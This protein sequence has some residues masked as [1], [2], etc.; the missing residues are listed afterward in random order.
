MAAYFCCHLSVP[1]WCSARWCGQQAGRQACRTRALGGVEGRGAV[2]QHPGPCCRAPGRLGVCWCSAVLCGLALGLVR[3]CPQQGAARC[4]G[5]LYSGLGL[6]L[7][8]SYAILDFCQTVR[9]HPGRVQWC[10]ARQ[11]Q[12]GIIIVCLRPPQQGGHPLP[13]QP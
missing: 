1:V 9:E 6:H 2:P 13:S 10:G 12:Q 8:G 4:C 7:R 3:H 5:L 11:I